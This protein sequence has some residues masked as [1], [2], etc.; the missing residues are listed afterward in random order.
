MQKEQRF[1]L[2]E[3]IYGIYEKFKSLIRFGI[4]G[5]VNTLVDFSVFAMF[6]SLFGVDKLICQVVGYSAGIINSFILNKLWTFENNNSKFNTLNQMIRFAG[7]N[8]VSL[9]VSLMGLKVI[10]DQYGLNTYV[11]KIIVTIL[12]Q[13]IN[14]FGYK[15]LVFKSKT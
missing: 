6:H 2:T 7:I 5:V 12:A 8:I 3:G 11:S 1:Y 9:A 4:V 15:L 14:Y 10:S 13:A